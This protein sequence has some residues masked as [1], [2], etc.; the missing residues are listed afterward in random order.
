MVVRA[1]FF[2]LDKTV[3]ATRSVL[4]LGGTL[5]RDGLITKRTIVRGLKDRIQSRLH[6]AVAEVEHQDLWQRAALGVAMVS[7]ENHHIG[8]LLGALR[9]LV[10]AT[11]GAEIIDWQER[12]E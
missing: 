6:A 3:I 2:D 5:Y 7:G 12:V 9:R 4:A 1:A 8:E 11:Y 10:E